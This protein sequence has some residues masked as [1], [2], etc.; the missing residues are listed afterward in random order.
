MYIIGFNTIHFYW[1]NNYS[2][3][4]SGITEKFAQEISVSQGLLKYYPKNNTCDSLSGQY[5]FD[6]LLV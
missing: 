2:I 6:E 3:N 5:V 4:N 1:Y